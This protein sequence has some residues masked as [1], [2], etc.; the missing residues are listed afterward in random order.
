MNND[1][2]IK[3]AHSAIQVVFD[4]DM[5]NDVDDALALAL[6]HEM[7]IRR[8]VEVLAVTLSIRDPLAAPYIDSFN[9][10]YG[11]P[12]I[13][14]GDCLH[15]VFVGESKF[16]PLANER[17]LDGELLFPREERDYPDSTALLRKTLARAEDHSVVIIQTGFFTN[18][19]RLLETAGD[20]D[21][22]LNGRELVMKKVRY[23][24][25]MA[26]AFKTIDGDP[27]YREF[28]VVQDIPS[29]QKVA[30]AW[31][32]PFQHTF[33]SRRASP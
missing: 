8:Q 21:S 24:S 6:L 31:P 29:A 22:P 23:V 9:R 10:Q 20:G 25:L 33:R 13:P 11:R 5:G 32:V 14:I 18:L 27:R 12:E 2:Q 26:G 3:P 30:A 16:L 28:N 15:G 1:T 4:T 7:E 17:T 19:A